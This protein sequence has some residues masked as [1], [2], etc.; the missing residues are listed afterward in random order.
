MNVS[1]FG[2]IDEVPRYAPQ[3]GEQ[4]LALFGGTK[5]DLSRVN[6][7]ES[8]RLSALSVFGGIKIIVPRGTDVVLKGFAVF[9]GRKYR[10]LP[11]RSTEEVRNVIYLNSVAIFGGIDVIEADS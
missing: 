8:L 11:E 4:F 5:V 1:L 3:D 10:P 2:D 7:P 9:G 6:L